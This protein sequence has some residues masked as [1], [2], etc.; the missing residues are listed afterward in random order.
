MYEG[1]STEQKAKNAKSGLDSMSKPLLQSLRQR[2]RVATSL[3]TSEAQIGLFYLYMAC[4][5][6]FIG[7]LSLNIYCKC[8][9]LLFNII[10]NLAENIGICGADCVKQNYLTGMCAFTNTGK[11]C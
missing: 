4:L 10:N 3:Y 11:G 6:H 9:A 1:T 2:I 8:V 5:A 7:S